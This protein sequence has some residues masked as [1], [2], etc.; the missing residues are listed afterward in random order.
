MCELQAV[1]LIDT[2]LQAQGELL[3]GTVQGTQHPLQAFAQLLPA[4][5]LSNCLACQLQPV[6]GCI[7][8][9]HDALCQHKGDM[10]VRNLLKQH[11]NEI[12]QHIIHT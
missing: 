12:K 9:V 6:I 5:A 1:C 2:H 10:K 3:Q 4:V 11:T 8:N 7:H